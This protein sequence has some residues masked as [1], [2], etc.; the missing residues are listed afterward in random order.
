MK[1]RE[2]DTGLLSASENM[3]LDQALLELQVADPL[4]TLRFLSFAPACVLVGYF[5]EVDQEIRRGYCEEQGIEINRRITGGG[6][7]YFDP[8]QLGW[9]LIAPANLFPYQSDELYRIV[10]NAVAD[11]LRKLGI[12]AFF[13]PRNDIEVNGKKISGMGGITLKN[14]FLFQGTLLVQDK[15]EEMLFS[16]KVPIEKLKPKEIDSIRERV[17]CIE[18]ELGSIPTREELKEAIKFGMKKN[19]G[20]ETF[21]GDLRPS[22]KVR[23]EKLKAYFSSEDWIYKIKFPENSQGLL[24]GTFRSPLGTIKANLHINTKPKI[25]KATYITGDFFIEKRELIFDLE[26]LLKNIPLKEDKILKIIDDFF[27]NE[28]S[29]P[30]DDLMGAFKEA[31]GKWKWIQFGFTPNEANN[32]FN[33]NFQPGEE[34]NPKVFL[35]PYCSKSTTCGFRRERG[36]PQCGGCTIGDGFSLAER[37]NLETITILTFEDLMDHFI[38]L[39]QRGITEYIGSC[40]EPFYIKHQERFRDSGLKGLLIN[41]ENSTCYDLGKAHDAY[42]GTFESQTDLNL[43]L[44]KKVFSW[45]YNLKS[46]TL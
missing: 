22:E 45:L 29:F 40:C 16:L 14:A 44:I 30:V 21:K 17:T 4:P 33:V 31:F 34:F 7:I 10:G 38:I 9:E 3:V 5:Q 42:V 41:I 46:G 36:C 27:K 20:I 2:L 1:F 24:T 23:A 18:K 6:T 35:F 12:D 19:L 26:R 25:L 43:P 11:G 39:K 8:S 32:I 37:F 28:K 13:K 15:I